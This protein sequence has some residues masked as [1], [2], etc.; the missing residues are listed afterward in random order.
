[1]LT[2]KGRR[3]RRVQFRRLIQVVQ[4]EYRA[5]GVHMREQKIERNLLEK[6]GAAFEAKKQLLAQRAL[7]SKQSER[8]QHFEASYKKQ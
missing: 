1:M 6:V 3:Y 7:L 4:K 5:R 8:T 2:S